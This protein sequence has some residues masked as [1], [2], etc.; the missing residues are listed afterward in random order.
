MAPLVLVENPT[1]R[2]GTLLLLSNLSTLEEACPRVCD[3][4]LDNLTR[5]AQSTQINEHLYHAVVCFNNLAAVDESR[6]K[7]KEKGIHKYLTTLLAQTQDG[8]IQKE[9]TQALVELGEL[10]TSDETEEAEEKEDIEDE[11]AGKEELKQQIKT[12][13]DRLERETKEPE[14]EKLTLEIQQILLHKCSPDPFH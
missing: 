12:L 11:K 3:Q 14:L 10:K 7:L 1:V 5:V 9:V 4:C 2:T 8:D 6:Q 13:V